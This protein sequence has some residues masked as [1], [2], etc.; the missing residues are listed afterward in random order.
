[1]SKIILISLTLA[2]KV[3]VNHALKMYKEIRPN[4]K[5]YIDNLAYIVS[6]D[7][8]LYECQFRTLFRSLLLYKLHF[9]TDQIYTNTRLTLDHTIV[10]LR[11]TFNDNGLDCDEGNEGE[12]K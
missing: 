2:E 5:T 3:I 10:K 7:G 8:I 11:R 1:M 6:R 4:D 9:S 12:A